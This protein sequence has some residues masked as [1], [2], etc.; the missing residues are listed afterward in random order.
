MAGLPQPIKSEEKLNAMEQLCN[1]WKLVIHYIAQIFKI[2]TD[3][4][5]IAEPRIPPFI[6]KWEWELGTL[7]IEDYINK[8]LRSVHSFLV[9]IIII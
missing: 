7:L 1:P 6:E 8:I 3:I 9:V 2:N 4:T 5:D